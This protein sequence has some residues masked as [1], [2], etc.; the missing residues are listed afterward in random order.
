MSKPTL[1]SLGA[2]TLPRN[3]SP[4]GSLPLFYSGGLFSSW[5]RPIVSLTAEDA[6]I[7]RRVPTLHFGIYT[8]SDIA[9]SISMRTTMRVYESARARVRDDVLIARIAD[10]MSA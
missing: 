6:E 10:A 9:D 7:S 3:A 5:S 4:M 8:C 2:R 1:K